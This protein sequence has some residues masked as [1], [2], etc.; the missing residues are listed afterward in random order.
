[1]SYPGH[2]LGGG[3][4]SLQRYSRCILQLQP[5]GQNLLSHPS[6]LTSL[7]GI[8]YLW[9]KMVMNLKYW[10]SYLS[11]EKMR[12]ALPKHDSVQMII[13]GSRQRKLFDILKL[14]IQITRWYIYIPLWADQNINIFLSV[15]SPNL[16]LTTLHPP[17]DKSILIWVQ[18]SEEI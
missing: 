3:L 14:N 4:I 18:E 7:T 11:N 5:T 10:D 9:T 1:M 16:S 2:S 17:P 15:L 13:I 8:S 6:R 12:P